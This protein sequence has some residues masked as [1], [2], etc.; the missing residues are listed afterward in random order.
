MG[1]VSRPSSKMGLVG[2]AVQE[3]WPFDSQFDGVWSLTQTNIIWFFSNFGTIFICIISRQSSKIGIVGQS[4]QELWPFVNNSTS[5]RA[6]FVT[7]CH[8]CFR[9]A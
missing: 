3:L 4:V 2:Q 8:S 5:W 6:Y 1:I 7:V 9:L